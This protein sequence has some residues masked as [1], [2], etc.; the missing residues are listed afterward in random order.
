MIDADGRRVELEAAYRT[1]F[2]RSSS[3]LTWVV[4]LRNIPSDPLR[5]GL[6]TIAG[7]M[8]VGLLGAAVVVG[9]LIGLVGLVWFLSG[10]RSVDPM[11]MWSEPRE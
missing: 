8:A 5:E 10:R 2:K 6:G 7:V 11:A 4:V 1:A 9:A 3:S